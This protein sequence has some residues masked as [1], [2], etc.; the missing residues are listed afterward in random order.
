MNY[1]KPTNDSRNTGEK[2]TKTQRLRNRELEGTVFIH[3]FIEKNKELKESESRVLV[4]KER[5]WMIKRGREF[6]LDFKDSEIKKLKKWF[7]SLDADGGG[8]IGLEELEVPLIGLGFAENR[9]EVKD[10]MNTVDEDG[11]GDIEFPEFLS[12]IKNSGM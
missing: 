7:N 4:H 2:F 5:K 6:L 12:I 11:N 3:Y 8:S 1:W 10:I 9:E